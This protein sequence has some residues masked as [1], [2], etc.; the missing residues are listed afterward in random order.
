MKHQSIQH[1]MGCLGTALLLT[2]ANVSATITVD[3]TRDSTNE[4]EY[5]QLALQTN[6]SGWGSG[7]AIAN[8]YAADTGKLLNV[9]IAGRANGNA[10]I[11]F[12]DSKTGG[13]SSISNNLI[14]SGGYEG[15]INNLAPGSGTGMTFESGFE[16]DM[17]IRVY[18]TGVEAYASLFD[19]EKRIRVDLGRVDDATASHGPVTELRTLWTDVGADSSF[20][21]DAL[22]GVEMALNMA[23]L[24]VPEGSHDVKMMAVL[25]NDSSTF[26]SN[27][28]LGS[29]DGPADLAGGVNTVDFETMAGTQ[30]LTVSV[31]RPALVAGEDEDGD[32]ITNGADPFPLAQTRDITFS[33]NMNVEAAKGDFSAPSTVQVQFFSGSQPALSTLSLSDPDLDL[34]YTGTQ[35]DVQGFEGDSFGTYKFITNDPNNTNGGYEFGFDRTFNLGAAETLQVLNTEFFSNDSFLSFTAWADVNAGGQSATEDFDKDGVLNGIEHFM[36]ETGS[37]FTPNPQAINGVLTWPRGLYVDPD[38]FKI[39]TSEDLSDWSDATGSADTSDPAS[40][41]F[42]IPTATPKLFVRLEVTIP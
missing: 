20:Y 23:L 9:M 11:L 5:A 17:A 41:E 6:T 34:V 7:N 29:L 4:T 27:Q 22:D 24:G 37:S 25:V 39:W 35:S 10:I 3:G 31:D 38:S 40:V 8:I 1:Q 26:G 16:P 14:Q 28:A 32:G 36:G 30:T 15:D 18:G 42:T 33:V 2:S 19:F 21:G 12:I 13:V